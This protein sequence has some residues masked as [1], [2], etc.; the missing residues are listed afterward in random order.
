MKY[1]QIY[2]LLILGQEKRK[3]YKKLRLTI[4]VKQ[5]IDK[6]A[7]KGSLR[8]IYFGLIF[9][10]K[11]AMKFIMWSTS[12]NYLIHTKFP[13]IRSVLKIIFSISL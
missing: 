1:Q 4:W 3:T 2:A 7:Q 10:L 12:S 5:R 11:N 9:W 13:H 6:Q 8:I